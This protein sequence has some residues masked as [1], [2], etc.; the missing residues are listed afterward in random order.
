MFGL[1]NVTV[2]KM[3]SLTA[4]NVCYRR[5]NSSFLYIGWKFQKFQVPEYKFVKKHKIVLTRLGPAK[6]L[7]SNTGRRRTRCMSNQ[8]QSGRGVG[9]RPE[10]EC[11]VAE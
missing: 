5:N 10:V 2:D 11:R 7:I 8:L 1:L 3:C 6:G 4:I 9:G